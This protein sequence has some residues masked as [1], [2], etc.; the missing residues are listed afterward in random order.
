ML[1]TVGQND[2]R[3]LEILGVTASLFFGVVGIEVLALGL[4]HAQDASY[5]VFEQIV[6]PSGR[7]VQLELALLRIQ[8]VPAAVSEGLVN[9]LRRKCLWLAWCFGLRLEDGR[10]KAEDGVEHRQP[11]SPRTTKL[12][13]RRQE[14]IS[15]DEVERIAI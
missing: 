7:R 9:Q 4:K 3:G 2:E 6:C 8:Q 13:D 1:P 5:T 10:S 14:E 12:Y 15:L 11:Q